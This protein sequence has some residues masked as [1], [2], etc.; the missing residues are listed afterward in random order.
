MHSL[1]RPLI[2]RIQNFLLHCL[3]GVCALVFLPSF[4]HGQSSYVNFEGKQ[5]SPVRLSSDGTRLFA[6]NTPDARLSVFD[7][8][9]PSN[10]LLIAEIP[11]GVEP[12]S[13]NPR[14]ADEVWVVNESVAA[15]GVTFAA[16]GT[17]HVAD[18]AAASIAGL[19]ARKF[20]WNSVKSLW[21]RAA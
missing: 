3:L 18:G 8:T 21:Y 6:V 9:Q 20:V 12:V 1:K 11:V 19:T 7:V 14:T 2:V 16:S 15:N 5:T 17:S 10:P 4:L 13:V